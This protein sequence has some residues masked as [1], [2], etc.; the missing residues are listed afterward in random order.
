V[1]PFEVTRVFISYR[2]VDP[3]AI[4]AHRIAE[5]LAAHEVF[6]DANIQPGEEW[7]RLIDEH[8]DDADFARRVCCCVSGV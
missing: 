2:H 3:D 1:Y 7:G 4:V 8:L 5:A 6:I